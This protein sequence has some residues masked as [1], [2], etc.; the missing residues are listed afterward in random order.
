MPNLI[1]TELGSF[2][3]RLREHRCNKYALYQKMIVDPLR[4]IL[5]KSHRF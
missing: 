2:M 5:I 4:T 1:W 3:D